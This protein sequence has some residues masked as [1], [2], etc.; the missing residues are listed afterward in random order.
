[1]AKRSHGLK[2]VQKSRPFIAI[3]L[4]LMEKGAMRPQKAE[5]PVFA[6]LRIATRSV[7]GRGSRATFRS[8]SERLH[9]P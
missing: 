2:S 8:T 5:E 7:A 1:M 4:L 9:D 6:R 3:D